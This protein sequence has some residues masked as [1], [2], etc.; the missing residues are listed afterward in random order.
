[1]N[2]GKGG[3]YPPFLFVFSLESSIFAAEET[4]LPIYHELK[5]Q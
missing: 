4:I 3:I 2:I 1:M 5:N